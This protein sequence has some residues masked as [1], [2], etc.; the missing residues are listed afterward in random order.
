MQCEICDQD[1]ATI[2]SD[3]TEG[4]YCVSCYQEFEIEI[5][6]DCENGCRKCQHEED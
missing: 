4:Y 1:G 3:N 5:N 2:Y 6:C